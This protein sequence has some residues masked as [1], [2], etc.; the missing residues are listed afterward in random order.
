VAGQFADCELMLSAAGV[1]SDDGAY[2]RVPEAWHYL[3]GSRT[4]VVK[5][6]MQWRRDG[7][8]NCS[9]YCVASKSETC[10]FRQAGSSLPPLSRTVPCMR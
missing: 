9:F 4:V 10:A 1:A 5:I 7:V 8:L 6:L 3:L 2:Q